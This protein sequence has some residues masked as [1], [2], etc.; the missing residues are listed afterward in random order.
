MLRRFSAI[1]GIALLTV[2]VTPA[3]AH[4]DDS[5]YTPQTTSTPTLAGSSTMAS[6]ESDVPWIDYSVVM[7]DPDNAATSHTAYLRL[8]DGTN[9]TDL[10]LGELQNGRLSGRVLWPGASVGADGR[11]NGWP[12][13]TFENGRWVETSGNY[14]WTRGAITAE[15][16]VNPQISVAL[17]YPPA[18]ANCLTDPAGVTGSTSAL[19]AT[20]VSA[21]VL[22]LGIAGGVVVVAGIVLLIVRGRRRA[23]Q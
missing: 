11:G 8:S 1:L 6:C 23:E 5:N 19:A 12:G 14:A 15:I 9:S 17:S 21:V 22:P 18:S 3:V 13:W 10:L 4:A 20:G 16:H 7:T 2:F